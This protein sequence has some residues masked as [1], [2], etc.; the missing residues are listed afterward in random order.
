MP[1]VR[2]TVTALTLALAMLATGPTAQGA[3]A[4]KRQATNVEL[5][6]PGFRS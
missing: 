5:L 1:T 2:V 6:K 4:Q 3:A